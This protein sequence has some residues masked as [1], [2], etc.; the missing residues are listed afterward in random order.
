MTDDQIIDRWLESRR[1]P[2]T[3]EGYA[4]DFLRFREF[5]GHDKPLSAVELGDVQRYAKHLT[6]QKT[7]KKKKLR[8][9]R[10]ARLLNV[11]KSF[12][13]FAVRGEYLPKNPTLD[14]SIPKSE[15]ALAERLLTR[16]DVNRLIAAEDNPRNQLLLKVIFYSGARVSEAIGLQWRHVRANTHGGQ[17]TLFGKG[18]E[19]RVVVIPAE[20]YGALLTERERIGGKAN[21]YVFPSLK[22]PQ[23]SRHQVGRIVKQAA[24]KAGLTH[25][26][27]THWLRHANASIALDNGANLMV[28]QKTLGHRSIATTQKY[29]HVKPDDSSGLYLDKKR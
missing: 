26:I 3:R 7:T 24:K 11:I 23:L 14:V 22:S 6:R 9:S 18:A 20:I 19:T 4:A 29:L 28:I 15:N 12:Y 17:L 25:A 2:L 27:S 8:A 10:Q 1:S 5:I 13:A 16:A 21:D